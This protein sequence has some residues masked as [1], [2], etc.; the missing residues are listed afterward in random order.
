MEA[1]YETA[2][3]G[4]GREQHPTSLEEEMPFLPPLSCAG[5]RM[6]FLHGEREGPPPLRCALFR[7]MSG[8]CHGQRVVRRKNAAR[9]KF[10]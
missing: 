3:E 1:I 5:R 2:G 6:Q 10:E 9:E 4:G 8:A 7:R